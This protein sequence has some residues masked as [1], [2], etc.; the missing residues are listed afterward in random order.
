MTRL[1]VKACGPRTSLQDRGRAGF[2]RFG[3]SLSGGMDT[4]ALCSANLL[5][6]NAAGAA[7][8]EFMLLGGSFVLDEGE[9]WISV[10]GAPCS[11]S[12]DREPVRPSTAVRMRAGQ[13]LTI[14]PMQKGVYAYL[15]VEGSF[16]VPPQLGSRSLH[17]RARLGGFHQRALLEGDELPLGSSVPAVAPRNLPPVPLE[18]TQ[19]VRVVLGPQ[20]DFFTAA[21][22]ETLLSGTFTVTQEADRMGYR[23]AGPRIEHAS[24]YNIVSDGIV[25]G[26]VQVPGSGEPIVMMADRQT[27][28]GYP[29]IATV[30]SADLR[31]FAQRRPGDRVRFAAVTI[32]QAQD[33]ARVRARLMAALPAAMRRSSDGLPSLDDL[34]ALNLAG[35]AVDALSPEP[36]PD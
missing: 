1:L 26:S 8:I 19:P 6:G 33:L 2:Q 15:A 9:R 18:S 12:L 34:F 25:S 20:D 16:D 32:T 7:A 11:A 4:W 24:D 23:L 35:A 36:G 14:G 22:I 13:S 31:V 17:Q 29:K 21:G 27:T 10:T 30:I 3:V 28:G 5:V